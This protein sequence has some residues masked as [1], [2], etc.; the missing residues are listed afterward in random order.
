MIPW[1]TS[2]RDAGNHGLV[3]VL[4]A[5]VEPESVS[6]VWSGRVAVGKV[7]LL[8]G[9]PGLGKSTVMLDVLAR[10]SRGAV[11]PDGGNAPL[12]ESVILSAE[13]DLADTIRPR[14][15]ALHADPS[16][17][18]AIKAVRGVD[19]DRLFS[20]ADD[21]ER[22]DLFLEE[23]PAIR[24]VGIDPLSAYLGTATDSYKDSEVRAILAPLARIAADRRVAVLGI[25]HLG[26]SGQRPALYRVLGS[27]AFTAA[28][29]LVLAVAEHPDKDGRRVLAPVKQNICA[30]SPT[31][32]FRLDGGRLA[33]DGIVAAVDLDAVLGGGHPDQEVRQDAADWL[34]EILADGPLPAKD[35][36]A[37]AREAGIGWRSVE[38]AKAKLRVRSVKHGSGIASRWIWKLPETAAASTDRGLAA[39]R[40]LENPSD[41]EAI[42]QD[43]KTAK[44]A[45]EV[46]NGRF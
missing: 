30:P 10:A 18:Y 33:W 21:L 6:F 2:P 37:A 12:C 42:R 29:R 39:L 5:A 38:G 26:K 9:D 13:D 8:V 45:T 40:S 17:I 22:L 24:I 28:A 27:I 7:N 25:M 32:A 11:W 41:S 1:P 31:L 20:L 23:H 4:L 3:S 14:L 36:Q 16:K 35:L 19:C 43:R 46:G 34:R 44:T 15:D